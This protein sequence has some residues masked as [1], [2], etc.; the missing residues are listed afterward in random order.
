MPT[1]PRRNR[2]SRYIASSQRPHKTRPVPVIDWK[3]RIDGVFQSFGAAFR[4]AS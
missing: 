3:S 1:A 4:E 2:A